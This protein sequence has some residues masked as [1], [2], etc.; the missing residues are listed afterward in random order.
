MDLFVY[1]YKKENY[2]IRIAILPC[3]NGENIVLRILN[4]TIK[5]LSLKKLGLFQILR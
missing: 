1:R 2:D 4:T 3:N 5:D